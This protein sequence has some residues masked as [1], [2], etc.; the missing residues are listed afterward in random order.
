M[1]DNSLQEAEYVWTS[2]VSSCS[3]WHLPILMILLLSNIFCKSAGV[4]GWIVPT[5]SGSKNERHAAMTQ[6]QTITME[7]K[8][9]MYLF[10]W[11]IKIKN[12][13][14]SNKQ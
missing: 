14:K 9:E 12:E 8:L 13:I 4:A 5:V 7:A 1:N 2:I 6:K 3:L 11:K 10:F